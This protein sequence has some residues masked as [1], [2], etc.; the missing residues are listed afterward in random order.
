MKIPNREKA[1]VQARKLVDYLLSESHP[2]G[3]PKARFFR[4]AGFDAA[5]AESLARAFVARAQAAEVVGTEQTGHG[6]KY[7]VEGEIDTPSGTPRRVRVVWIIDAGSERP[8]FVT[9]YPA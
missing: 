5:D 1:Y 2:V 6:A 3:A 8:R 4:A 7:V 9:A